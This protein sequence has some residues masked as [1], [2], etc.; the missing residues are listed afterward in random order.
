MNNS[1]INAV[2]ELNELLK[3]LKQRTS[4][5]SLTAVNAMLIARKDPGTYKGFTVV[6]T[7]LRTFCDRLN[8]QAEKLLTLIYKIVDKISELKKLEN[9]IRILEL[10]QAEIKNSESVATGILQISQEQKKNHLM[11]NEQLNHLLGLLSLELEHTS[12]QCIQGDN[13][14]ILAKIESKAGVMNGVLNL[15]ADQVIESV[16]N[17][18]T[19]LKDVTRKLEQGS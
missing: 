1:D 10:T 11:L 19:T 5:I 17:I 4:Q 9:T 2:L 13:L 6:T 18:Q 14:G 15:V 7:E 3:S 12:K 8:R 16:D